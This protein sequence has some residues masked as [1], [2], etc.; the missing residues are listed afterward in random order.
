MKSQ[1]EVV[2]VDP[3][4]QGGGYSR[5]RVCQRPRYALQKPL[6]LHLL[7]VHLSSTSSSTSESNQ[8]RKGVTGDIGTP[9]ERFPLKPHLLLCSRGL[10]RL[11]PPYSSSRDKHPPFPPASLI[12]RAPAL[13]FLDKVMLACASRP[14]NTLSPVLDPAACSCPTLCLA[15]NGAQG[16]RVSDHS[17]ASFPMLGLVGQDAVAPPA[18][19]F[20]E[21]AD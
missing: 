10:S 16:L 7:A 3:K 15:C 17:S 2:K 8:H 11:D 18:S 13:I 1:D 9:D 5:S 21:R 12:G 6:A 20:A 19:T 14:D 4:G